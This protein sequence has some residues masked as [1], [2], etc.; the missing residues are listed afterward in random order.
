MLDTRRPRPPQARVSL[1]RRGAEILLVGCFETS[2][3]E[4][5]GAVPS[6]QFRL[7]IE[8]VGT[9]SSARIHDIVVFAF[10]KE[11]AHFG[12]RSIIVGA[13]DVAAGRRRSVDDGAQA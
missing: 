8:T 3:A 7:V 12:T 1:R 10:V 13:V 6:Y 11:P 2:T 4:R 5:T 9:R